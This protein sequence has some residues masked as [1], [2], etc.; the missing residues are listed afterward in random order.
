MSDGNDSTEGVTPILRQSDTLRNGCTEP[1]T[2]DGDD[3]PSRLDSDIAT[4][5]TQQD[6]KHTHE[7]GS[8]GESSL[9]D[10]APKCELVIHWL[11]DT[12]VPQYKLATQDSPTGQVHTT[13]AD[14]NELVLAQDLSLN[15][16]PSAL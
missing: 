2:W 5:Q 13:T 8:K 12:S 11:A 14:D 3:A 16:L 7:M 15:E 4:T 6:S 1:F 10:D 9:R